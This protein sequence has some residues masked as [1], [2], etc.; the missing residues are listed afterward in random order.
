M[1]WTDMISSTV[2]GELTVGHRDLTDEQRFFVKQFNAYVAPSKNSFK[3]V[4]DPKTNSSMDHLKVVNEPG[5]SINMPKKDYEILCKRI[6][7]S[8]EEEYLRTMNPQAF[9]LWMKYQTYINL[10]K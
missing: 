8:Y 6:N 5:V 7:D 2:Y 9:E 4:I 10:M 1:K 3:E